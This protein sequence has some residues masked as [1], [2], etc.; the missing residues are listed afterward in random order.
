M[1]SEHGSAQKRASNTEG[2]ECNQQQWNQVEGNEENGEVGETKVSRE[3]GN[4]RAPVHTAVRARQ[5]HAQGSW[6]AEKVR[7]RGDAG[8]HPDGHENA[9]R[10]S[11]TLL[12][13]AF[14]RVHYGKVST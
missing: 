2:G 4:T 3:V 8:E 9:T 10:A 14:Q 11:L 12:H 1:P 13:S 7:Q 6:F 5:L